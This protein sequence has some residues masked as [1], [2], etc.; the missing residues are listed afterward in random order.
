MF[1]KKNQRTTVNNKMFIDLHPEISPTKHK[2]KLHTHVKPRVRPR[3]K[4]KFRY[5]F[6]NYMVHRSLISPYTW[7]CAWDIGPDSL[8]KVDNWNAIDTSVP[9]AVFRL[10]H[11]V[12]VGL[13]TGYM[14]EGDMHL[15]IKEIDKDYLL[16]AY[17]VPNK[18][19]AIA[20]FM[21]DEEEYA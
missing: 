19:D 11:T 18:Q 4:H 16:I 3:V 13:L 10:D 1:T 2:A 5:D 7:I 8:S 21:Q 15:A 20:K 12:R 6:W 14:T 9:Y 17:S